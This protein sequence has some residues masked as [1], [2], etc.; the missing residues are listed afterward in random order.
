MPCHII[1]HVA[2]SIVILFNLIVHGYIGAMYC[3]SLCVWHS[4]YMLYDKCCPFSVSS[5][6]MLVRTCMWMNMCMHAWSY[7]DLYDPMHL[8]NK[9]TLVLIPT[10]RFYENAKI[11]FTCCEHKMCFWNVCNHKIAEIDRSPPSQKPSIQLQICW[12]TVHVLTAERSW[13][14][15]EWAGGKGRR[16]EEDANQIQISFPFTHHKNQTI[17]AQAWSSTLAVH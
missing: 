17:S 5:V 14:S 11:L 16:R 13:Y 6:Y 4:L 8:V 7:T 15:R 2:Y 12:L 9:V 3:R 1:F 10:E